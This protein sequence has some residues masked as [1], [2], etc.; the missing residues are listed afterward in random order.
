MAEVAPGP[1]VR[2]GVG[3]IRTG[4]LCCSSQPSRFDPSRAPGGRHTAWAYCHVPN[5]SDFDIDWEDRG[6]GGTFRAGVLRAD[7]EAE[8]PGRQRHWRRTIRTASAETLTV[9]FRDLGQLFSPSRPPVQP[10]QRPLD[11]PLHLLLFD[12]A[13]GGVHGMCGYFAARGRPAPS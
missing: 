6:A 2:S 13:G 12:A 9:V 11:R 4:P 3:V 8:R 10:L 5:G 1:N 7:P